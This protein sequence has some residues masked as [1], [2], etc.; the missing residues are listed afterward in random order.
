MYRIKSNLV[1]NYE[2]STLENYVNYN[3]F[4]DEQDLFLDLRA[5]IYTNLSDTYN[6]KY[7]YIL[8]EV[9]LNKNL[10]SDKLGSGS[11]STNIKIHNYDTNKLTKFFVND[12]NWNIKEINHDS[13]IKSKI[14]GKIKK[15]LTLIFV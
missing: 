6:D 7:E 8:P 14:L 10:Y 13:G 3:Y 4:D 11:F 1:D 12:F 5:S 2:I 15:L 9:N